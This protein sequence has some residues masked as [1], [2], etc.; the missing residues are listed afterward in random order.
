MNSDMGS[1]PGPKT[2]AYARVDDKLNHVKMV[3]QEAT[4]SHGGPHDALYISKSRK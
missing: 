2:A 3:K 4:L 1:V